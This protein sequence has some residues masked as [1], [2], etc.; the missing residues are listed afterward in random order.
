MTGTMSTHTSPPMRPSQIHDKPAIYHTSIT[1]YATS[2]SSR[3]TKQRNL[4]LHDR[5]IS[6][7]RALL[8]F[9]SVKFSGAELDALRNSAPHVACEE[10]LRKKVRKARWRCEEELWEAKK[11]AKEIEAGL[12]KEIDMRIGNQRVVHRDNEEVREKNRVLKEEN[13]VLKDDIVAWEKENDKIMEAND[14]LVKELKVSNQDNEEL[15]VSIVELSMEVKKLQKRLK[16]EAGI[17]QEA[18]GVSKKLNEALTKRNEAFAKRKEEMQENDAKREVVL[19]QMQEVMEQMGE[20]LQARDERIKWLEEVEKDLVLKR[21]REEMQVK[22]ERIKFLVESEQERLDQLRGMRRE[23]DRLPECGCVTPRCT[24]EEGGHQADEEMADWIRQNGGEKNRDSDSDY[25]A[26]T[27]SDDCESEDYE[28]EYESDEE[29]FEYESSEAIKSLP[30]ANTKL[31]DHMETRVAD[32]IAS[33]ENNWKEDIEIRSLRSENA[34]LKV[35][36][37]MSLKVVLVQ[38][39]NGLQRG[40]EDIELEEAALQAEIA[41]PEALEAS[42]KAYLLKETYNSLKDMAERRPFA[43]TQQKVLEIKKVELNSKSLQADNDELKTGGESWREDIL[44]KEGSRLIKGVGEQSFL[45]ETQKKSEPSEEMEAEKPQGMISSSASTNAMSIR[46]H[47]EDCD[48]IS[49]VIRASAAT[50]IEDA[51]VEEEDNLTEDIEESNPSAQ[52]DK[53]AAPIKELDT[54]KNFP[55]STSSS[56]STTSTTTIKSGLEALDYRHLTPSIICASTSAPSVSSS[57]KKAAVG[58]IRE[59]EENEAGKAAR[60]WWLKEQTRAEKRKDDAEEQ[61]RVDE[62][63]EERVADEGEEQRLV[64][65]TDEQRIA[66]EVGEQELADV[67]GSQKPPSD[68]KKKNKKKNKPKKKARPDPNAPQKPLAPFVFYMQTARVIIAS[69]LGGLSPHDPSVDTE[70]QKRWNEMAG[71]DKKLWISAYTDKLLLYNARV[72]AYKNGIANAGDWSDLQAIQHAERNNVENLPGGQLFLVNEL[73]S[74]ERKMV[75]SRMKEQEVEFKERAEWDKRG[76]ERRRAPDGT[77][78]ETGSRWS[79]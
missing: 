70:G 68:K 77:W 51:F 57:E 18:A 23:R 54:P 21:M 45:E 74:E 28:S 66:E 76:R 9:K 71:D 37:E 30:A 25:D 75:K 63:A 22:E 52:D 79:D 38:G 13:Q 58:S 11:Q 69:D 59:V 36:V 6:Q 15:M 78:I 49:T 72:H 14:V 43:E 16:N 7:Y 2:L 20:E 31:N 12:R 24:C 46:S 48:D 10:A 61:R 8:K 4:I 60:K 56:T 34:E 3:T 73:T 19:Q 42:V 62:A 29:G 65:E 39:E 33:E 17:Y 5:R 64:Y 47:C 67:G 35:D 27:T 26:D 55:G 50:S 41:K 32:P 40:K 53:E 1:S 44:A